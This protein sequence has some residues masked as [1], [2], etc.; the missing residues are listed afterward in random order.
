MPRKAIIK[1]VKRI[2]LKIGSGVLALPQGGLDE[3]IIK[4]IAAS[5]KNLNDKGYEVVIVSSGAILAGIG[6]LNLKER[7][8]DIPT[9]QATA[10]IGQSHLIWFYEKHF[11]H[12]KMRTA[13]ILLTHDDLA[14]RRR[15]T[16]AKNTLE[17]LLRHGVI[18]IIN[19]NDTVVVEE[20][21]LGDNDHLSGLVTALV[22]ADILVI[23][24][25]IDGI[26][27]SDPR[28]DSQAHLIEEIDT[29]TPQI[30]EIMKGQ[31]DSLGNNF[32]GRFGT[33][34]IK[35]KI[36]AAEKAASFGAATIIANGRVS[37]ILD[38]IFSGEKVG[39]LILPRQDR[40]SSRKHW[41]AHALKPKGSLVVDDGARLA[42]TRDGKSLL[43]SGI[44]EVKGTFDSGDCVRCLGSEGEEIARGLVNY[45]AEEIRR[46]K[47]K[48]SNQIETILGYKV[49]DEVIHRNNMAFLNS[50]NEDLLENNHE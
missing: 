8:R 28:K 22:E 11:N 6:R 49:Y 33:G 26:Y 12:Y 42:L 20:I 3:S 13:Q 48:Q 31:S 43:P 9:R 44:R 45:S 39:T 38:R 21:K 24:S 37:G 4:E 5:V 32:S 2:V 40:L 17:T 47:G 34:G 7:P 18:P 41:I 1:K 15:Y 23:L 16:N 25:D 35:T 27:S 19:E 30:R 14:H 46:V 10:A 29:I 36:E 50:K